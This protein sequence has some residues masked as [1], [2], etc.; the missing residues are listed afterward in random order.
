MKVQ[1]NQ[2]DFVLNIDK[3]FGFPVQ[4]ELVQTLVAP[5]FV[6]FHFMV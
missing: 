5:L 3:N 1:L 6:G 2:I 4:M